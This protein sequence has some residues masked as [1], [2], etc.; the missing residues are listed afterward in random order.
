MITYRRL[1]SNGNLG[2]QLWQIAGTV[3]V[4]FDNGSFPLFPQWKYA[5]H[6]N[7]PRE[8]FTGAQGQESTE[9]YDTEPWR[10]YL[11]HFP[12][13]EP[14]ADL[15]LDIFQPRDLNKFRD[16][17]SDIQPGNAAAVSVR[18]G[19][20]AEEWRGHGMLT[21]DYYLD[22]WP[23][24]RVLVFS[25][26]PQWCADNLPGEVVQCD[27]LT[28][29]FL[30]SQCREIV[31]SNSSFAWWGAFLSRSPVTFPDPWF[32]SLPVGSMAVPGWKPVPR[33]D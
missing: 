17:V 22:N 2:N 19:D 27:P 31:I 1:G 18:R 24:G 10:D 21:K 33:S 23:D 11:Q 8:W 30:I 16:I 28:G 7:V 29:L 5:E 4:A 26:D 25:D 3:A 6:F 20:Y 32:T 13:I 9:F 15:L 12:L 14:Y